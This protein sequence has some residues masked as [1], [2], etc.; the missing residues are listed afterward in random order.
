MTDPAPD[1]AT[2]TA[3]PPATAPDAS[4]PST[5]LPR[6]GLPV[7]ARFLAWLARTIAR[8]VLRIRVEGLEHL[9]PTGAFIL[10]PNHISN[11]D[12]PLIHGW[13][14]PVVGQRPRFLA[15][16][17]LFKGIAGRFMRL[18]GVV[19]VKTGGSDIEAY[20]VAKGLLADGDVVV[21]FPEGTRSQDGR[22]GSPKP[23]VTMLASREG[24]PVVPVGISGSDDFLKKGS[25]LPR[26][27]ARVI[28]RFGPAYQP[29]L[30]R[31]G[32]RRSAL[33]AADEELTR[34]IAALVE[35]RHRGDV[36]PWTGA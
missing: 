1:Q 15:K 29:S 7:D 32:D 9:P 28:V 21:I 36:E 4:V 25:K 34:R 17:V 35:P 26:V 16:E 20:R 19:P 22:L 13:A 12:P 3:R 30:P 11:I 24:V 27:G 31:G 2:E 14:A 6:K 33:A 10:A 8:C 5:Q 23:G 18:E